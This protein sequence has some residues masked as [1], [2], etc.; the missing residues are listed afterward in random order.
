MKVEFSSSHLDFV[1]II[2]RGQPFLD[3]TI[4]FRSRIPTDTVRVLNMAKLEK[5]QLHSG[6]YNLVHYARST[7]PRSKF[8][9]ILCFLL[10]RNI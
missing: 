3:E 1:K 9:I 5:K 6:Q 4:H 2:A 7:I 10:G 8:N